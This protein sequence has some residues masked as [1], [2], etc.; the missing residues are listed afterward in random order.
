M[1]GSVGLGGAGTPEWVSSLVSCAEAGGLC[2]ILRT[3]PQRYSPCKLPGRRGG[4]GVRSLRLGIMA[5]RAAGLS[6]RFFKTSNSQWNPH[7]RIIIIILPPT[8]RQCFSAPQPGKRRPRNPKYGSRSLL[9]A[10]LLQSA[11][12]RDGNRY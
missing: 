5:N 2:L 4:G 10:A 6:T 7:F 11:T 8:P 9:I 12:C 3:R 1:V